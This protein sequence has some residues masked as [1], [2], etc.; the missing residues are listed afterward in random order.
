[1]PVVGGVV[2]MVSVAVPALVPLMLTGVVEPK[3]SVGG[4][5]APAGLVVTTAVR[6]TLPVNP[7]E[8]VMVMADVLPV[9]APAATETVV[10][11]IVKP[12]VAVVVTVTVAVPLAAL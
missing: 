10:P 11:E 4:F 7:A 5:T 9:V 8:G 12:G 6:A 2:E 3:L 1:M